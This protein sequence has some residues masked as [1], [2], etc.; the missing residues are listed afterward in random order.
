MGFAR[1]TMPSVN[2]KASNHRYTTDF[3]VH[4]QM[5]AQVWVPEGLGPDTVEMCSPL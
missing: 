5:L 3:T 4:A 1:R 2:G